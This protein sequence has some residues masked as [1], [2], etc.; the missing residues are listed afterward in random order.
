MNCFNDFLAFSTRLVP[1]SLRQALKLFAGQLTEEIPWTSFEND[2]CRG[3]L[4][5]KMMIT[6]Y[7][8]RPH[9]P[10]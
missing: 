8:V 2:Q 9:V 5:A 7:P 6:R 3:Q 10:I 4:W 1:V